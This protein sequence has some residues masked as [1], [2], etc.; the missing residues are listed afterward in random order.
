MMNFNG[1]TV[2]ITGAA[3]GI[4]FATAEA[5]IARGANVAICDMGQN[6]FESAEKLGKSA[7]GFIADVTKREQAAAFVA[8]TVEKFGAIDVLVNN[9]GI[10]RD[11][12][13]LNMTDEM[14]DMVLAVNLKSM[15][16]VTQEAFKVMLPAGGGCVIGLS[17]ISG[18]L[19]NFGQAN[20]AAS[21][22]GVEGFTRTLCREFAHKGIRANAVAPGFIVTDMTAK[23]PQKAIDRMLS[24]IPMRRGGTVDEVASVVC[25]LASDDASFING[26]TIAINGGSYNS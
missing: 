6:V 13:F 14:W 5:F 20:Y 4:G 7:M 15:F 26:Q 3:R 1:K 17:S 18:Q 9:A 10:T 19:G 16:I 12:Q 8:A 21:K 25:F 2:M 22:A 11:A 23:M 24:T